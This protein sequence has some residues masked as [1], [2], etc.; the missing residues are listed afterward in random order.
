MSE[1]LNALGS[2]ILLKHVKQSAVFD[3]L[4]HCHCA[5][6]F[7]DFSILATNFNKLKIFLTKRD[8]P[9]LNRFHWNSLIKMTVLF[10]LLPDL[11][12]T[13]LSVSGKLTTLEL[14]FVKNED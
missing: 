6:K 1:R 12:Q 4:L 5:T 9:V 10:T 14:F 3:H 13:V 7:Q 8:K 2:P 11:K